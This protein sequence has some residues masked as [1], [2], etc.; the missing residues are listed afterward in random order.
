MKLSDVNIDLGSDYALELGFDSSVTKYRTKDE[1]M[2]PLGDCSTMGQMRRERMKLVE[3]RK[4][5]NNRDPLQQEDGGCGGSSINRSSISKA[6][7]N[8]KK[9]KKKKK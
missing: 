8:K 6:A 4:E 2:K 9:K 1:E 7:R 3:A 5:Q